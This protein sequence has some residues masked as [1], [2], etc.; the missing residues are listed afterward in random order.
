MKVNN[1]NYLNGLT[2]SAEQINA[3]VEG[4]GTSLTIEQTAAIAKIEGLE[5]SASEINEA[6]QNSHRGARRTKENSTKT[7]L[8]GK[9][10]SVL[11]DSLSEGFNATN[12]MGYAP[13][14]KRISNKVYG[15]TNFGLNIGGMGFDTTGKTVVITNSALDS[16]TGHYIVMPSASV[17]TCTEAPLNDF[18]FAGQKGKLV[19]LASDSTKT[20]TIDLLD[21]GNGNIG[22]LST[23][24]D[25]NGLSGEFDIPSDTVKI[26][27]TNTSGFALNVECFNIYT[28]DTDY[29]FI[30]Q[31]YRGRKLQ[32]IANTVIDKWFDNAEYAIFALGTNDSVLADF[33]TKINY[34]IAKY[35]AQKYT[36]LIILGIDSR[37]DIANDFEAELQRMND[38]CKGSVYIKFPNILTSNYSIADK[39]DL[40]IEGLI[41]TDLT[42][43]TDSGHKYLANILS[44]ALG[45]GMSVDTF[46]INYN[47][48]NRVKELETIVGSTLTSNL[49]SNNWNTTFARLVGDSNK[50]VLS[51]G[52]ITVNS[53]YDLV[54]GGNVL[55]GD[56]KYTFA[57]Y[58]AAA[59]GGVKIKASSWVFSGMTGSED[60]LITTPLNFSTYRGKAKRAYFENSIYINFS[61][62]V[63]MTITNEFMNF[64]EITDGTFTI[65][66]VEYNRG[67]TITITAGWHLFVSK[68]FAEYSSAKKLNVSNNVSYVF[69]ANILGTDALTMVVTEPMIRVAGDLIPIINKV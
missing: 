66:E 54:Y 36:K 50:V 2:V 34:I 37:R 17:M 15:S 44:D 49:V 28:N 7:H 47:L 62:N 61:R 11:G 31:S 60:F 19:C 46:D 68:N 20:V 41:D 14:T 8:F 16:L 25:A 59:A 18:Y 29:T 67:D 26:S 53:N 40:L 52:D 10:I 39:D 55:P 64:S 45:L 57:D 12:L 43:Y 69:R 38:E 56:Y 63:N 24:I 48:E 65:D 6:I 1:P 33:T 51:N 13:L 22:T 21:S 5:A 35:N 42:H 32:G 4:S 30:N 9:V 58:S 23:T 27:I 3:A